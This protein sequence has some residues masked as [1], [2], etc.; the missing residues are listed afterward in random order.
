ME[1]PERRPPPP[2]PD[3]PSPPAASSATVWRAA[4]GEEPWLALAF[5]AAVLTRGRGLP[6]SLPPTPTPPHATARRVPPIRDRDRRGD[7]ASSGQ[8]ELRRA[9]S[10]WAGRERSRGEGAAGL[11]PHRQRDAPVEA[12]GTFILHK[13]NSRQRLFLPSP[14]LPRHRRCPGRQPRSREVTQGSRRALC[15]AGCWAA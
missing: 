5:T 11:P 14:P 2:P 13:G 4:G 1:E 10:L 12:G 8:S 7:P 9:R 3:A 15:R 6:A